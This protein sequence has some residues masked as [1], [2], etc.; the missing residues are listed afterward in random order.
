MT[1][2]EIKEDHRRLQANLILCQ[3]VLGRIALCDAIGVTP[4][5]WTTRMKEPWKKFS[6][7]D[8]RII[9]Q[10]SGVEVETLLFGTVTL[11]GK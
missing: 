1:Q 10:A 6:Y 11:Y 5:T 4:S 9:A 3:K 7:D 2:K 8:F